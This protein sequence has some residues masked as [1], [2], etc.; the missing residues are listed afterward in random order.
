MSKIFTW[1]F[2]FITGAISG[3]VLLAVSTLADPDRW[4]TI[5]EYDKTHR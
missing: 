2:G 4:I 1:V 3:I 5:L